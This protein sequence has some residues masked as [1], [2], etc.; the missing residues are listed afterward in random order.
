MKYNKDFICSNSI[1][2]EKQKNTKNKF[3]IAFSC[4]F[5]VIC[6]L[7]SVF[8][9]FLLSREVNEVHADTVTEL[10]TFEGSNITVWGRSFNFYN[11]DSAKDYVKVDYG[12]DLRQSNIYPVF[13]DGNFLINYKFTLS[14]IQWDING[15]THYTEMILNTSYNQY[16]N[17]P[18]VANPYGGNTYQ[19]DSLDDN[20]FRIILGSDSL[21]NY[22]CLYSSLGPRNFLRITRSSVEFICN[23]VRVDMGTFTDSLEPRYY[24]DEDSLIK[25]QEFTT[26]NFIRYFDINDNYLEIAIPVTAAKSYQPQAFLSNRSYYLI[27]NFSNST[28]YKTAFNDG[29]NNGKE[30]GKLTGISEGFEDGSAVGFDSGYKEGL[31]SSAEYTW[32][33]LIGSLID[34][35]IRVLFGNKDQYGQFKSGLLSFEIFGV[36][37]INLFAGILTI[38]LIIFILRTTLGKG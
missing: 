16:D 37:M 36:N 38:A 35:P 15:A 6:I 29:F 21:V 8:T 20:V 11:R 12:S 10:Y 23:I 7:S 26:F 31:N 24:F 25:Y 1:S 4:L 14:D 5:F 33:G 27:N 19:P 30:D 17:S 28:V 32:F 9:Y 3:I 34:A 13:L 22:Y 2:V 18:L